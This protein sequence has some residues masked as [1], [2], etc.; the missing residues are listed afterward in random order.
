MIATEFRKLRTVRGPWV[1]LATAQLLIIAG[2]S[3]LLARGDI[4][5][6]TKVPGALA[7]VGLASLFPLVLGIMAVGSEYRH[8]TI[9]DT[10]LGTPDRSAVFVAKLV[11]YVTAGLVFAVVGTVTGF[12][13]SLLWTSVRGGSMGWGSVDLWRTIAGAAAWNVLFAAIGV[14]IGALLRNLVT[15]IVAA[16][17]WLALIEGVVGQVIGSGPARWLPFRAGSALDHLPGSPGLP[18]LGAAALLAVYAIA[19]A[20]SA[21]I[22]DTR[23][24]LT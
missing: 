21:A 10:Y 18:Q 23:R 2:A 22:A 4:N 3:G 20:L 7:H 6:P 17:A 16:L 8:R 19:L 15:A 5:D 12:V 9:T 14:A 24:D 13:V 1:L 11:V